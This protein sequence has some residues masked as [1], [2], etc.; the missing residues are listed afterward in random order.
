MD[1]S[2]RI[3]QALHDLTGEGAHTI[4]A[5]TEHGGMLYLGSLAQDLRAMPVVSLVG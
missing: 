5:V 1:A 4:T 2:G 3:I